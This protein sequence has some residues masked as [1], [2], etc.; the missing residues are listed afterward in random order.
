MRIVIDMQ[1]A[2]SSGSRNRG[3]GR[4]TSALVMGMLRNNATHEIILALNAAFPES[5]EAVRESVFDVLPLE[6]IKVWSAVSPISF[7]DSE[8]TF[9]RKTAELIR[10]AFIADLNP[11]VVLVTS[12]FEG[13]VDD[14]VSSIGR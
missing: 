14:A 6:N 11:D 1:G 4:Y 2:Q 8:H 9:Y 3:I 7:I 12:L 5:I 10:E 13:L